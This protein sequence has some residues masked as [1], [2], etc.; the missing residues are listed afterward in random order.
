MMIHHKREIGWCKWIL[1]YFYVFYW[2][3]HFFLHFPIII[4]EH[5][6]G[7][8]I[9]Y[10]REIMQFNLVLLMM[11]SALFRRTSSKKLRHFAKY[12]VASSCK[13][14]FKHCSMSFHIIDKLLLLFPGPSAMVF[15][16][17]D[18]F[19][20]HFGFDFL[21]LFGTLTVFKTL[22]VLLFKIGDFEIRKF[23]LL[24]GTVGSN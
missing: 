17:V 24:H 23:F 5:L 7:N 6:F 21:L 15:L 10:A 9:N 13:F 3:N 20:F 2:S 1:L 18:S 4:I 16:P 19:L 12:L 11:T 22:L 14:I 8:M